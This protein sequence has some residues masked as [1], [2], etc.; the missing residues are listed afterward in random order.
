MNDLW[1]YNATDREW[2]YL[3]PVCTT[4]LSNTTESDGTAERDVNGPRGRISP[5]L[6]GYQDAL[7]LFGG[8]AYGGESNFVELYPVGDDDQYP[9]LDAKYYLNDLWKYDIVENTWTELKPRL[10][11]TAR[12]A[13]R[14][15]HTATVVVKGSDVVMLLHGGNTWNDEIGDMWQYNLTSNVWTQVQG[16]GEYPSRRFAAT[17][18]AVGQASNL[19]AGSSRQS[20]RAL[21]YGGHGCLRG[22]YYSE[23]ANAA[24]T[25]ATETKTFTANG[26][27]Y[28]Y[29]VSA[30][31]L[32]VYDDG[33]GVEQVAEPGD[34]FLLLLE[35]ANVYT[36]YGE[37]I[38][39]E[40]LEDL[41]Q[42]LPDECPNDCSRAGSCSFNTCI[43]NSGFWGNDCSY[44]ECPGSNCTFDSIGRQMLC[45][46]CSG[47]GTCLNGACD[48]DYPASGVQCEDA[49]GQCTTCECY[50]SVF[51][52]TA[53]EE[54]GCLTGDIQTECPK[55][56]SI[57]SA[58]ECA[59][60]GV[61]MSGGIC[62]C[63]PGFTES[64]VV[65]RAG[66]ARIPAR[67]DPNGTVV[68]APECGY[69]ADLDTKY[70]PSA[71]TSAC[72]PVY[73]ADC[74]DF[75]YQVAGSPVFHLMLTF[76]IVV[77]T[78]EFSLLRI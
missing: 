11:H 70:N 40:E 29:S 14:Y 51:N 38:C 12:P 27:T 28:T 68:P 52:V 30:S 41:W 13:P 53:P 71:V 18:V 2:E 73:I 31:G 60:N 21:I 67:L 58:S 7:Y 1:V 19:R 22:Q 24:A 54:L 17:M 55:N 32:V 77:L 33:S 48:C 74:G 49:A 64:M 42:Y 50:D 34:P 5:S 20:G 39:T 72:E 78:F 47:R 8:Y 35:S 26:I 23:A 37:T 61:C 65:T 3:V 46:H 10:N 76:I 44:P 4:C 15:G 45:N 57:P 43:C 9:S 56:P 16:Q 69:D 6:V 66:D 59:G 75:L 63:Y 62:N 36:G 25:V